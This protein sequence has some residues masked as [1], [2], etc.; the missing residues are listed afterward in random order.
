MK[1]DYVMV[2]VKDVPKAIAFYKKAFALNTGYVEEDGSFATMKTG[3]TT[4]AFVDEKTAKGYKWSATKGGVKTGIEIVFAAADVPKAYQHALKSGAKALHK[5][6]EQ[7]WGG[8]Q[9][10]VLDPWG[11]VVQLCTPW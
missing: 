7:S 2:Y 10:W 8:V 11:T 1:L 9:G 5:P 6:A 3:T 4:L